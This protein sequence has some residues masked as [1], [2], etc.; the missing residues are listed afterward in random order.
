VQDMASLASAIHAAA[1]DGAAR[2][3]TD[4]RTHLNPR[5]MS[6]IGQL[7]EGLTR[8]LARRCP[9]CGALGWGQLNL[10][11]GL[12]CAWCSSPSL[13]PQDEIHGC[14][15]CGATTLLPRSDGVTE[16]DPGMCPLCNP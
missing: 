12:P 2:I 5:R 9:D 11:A 6:M 15:A 13:M 3:Q 14:T 16:P 8:R 10:A 4:M 7:A 1:T